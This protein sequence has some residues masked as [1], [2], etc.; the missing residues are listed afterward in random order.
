MTLGSAVIV[1]AGIRA[2]SPVIGPVVIALMLTIAWSP[3]AGWL[4]KRGLPPSVAALAGIVLGVLFVALFA[5]LVWESLGKLQNKLPASQL[6][7]P[8][9]HIAGNTTSYRVK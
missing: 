1:L 9:N 6:L 8:P 2:A 7:T 5:L 4:E 3:A